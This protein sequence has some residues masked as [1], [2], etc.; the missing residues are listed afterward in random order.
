MDAPT[1]KG[2]KGQRPGAALPPRRLRAPSPLRLLEWVPGG[3]GRGPDH[4]PSA[5]RGSLS[6]RGGRADIC[7]CFYGFT[8]PP[9]PGICLVGCMRL[10]VGGSSSPLPCA[11]LLFCHFQ[12]EGV[13]SVETDL[14]FKSIR[15][16]WGGGACV[17]GAKGVSRNDSDRCCTLLY[18][19][20]RRAAGFHVQ[21]FWTTEPP[22]PSTN[23]VNNP[24]ESHTHQTQAVDTPVH[25]GD[26]PFEPVF[27]ELYSS[28]LV[29]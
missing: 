7:C 9:P 27:S 5:S 20:C 19:Y 3:P 1:A 21:R 13:V 15:E 22:P 24:S 14:N 18:L 25:P 26:V 23:T 17:M 8:P 16:G 12:L 4:C 2:G 11:S 28:G 29:L 6:S 10:C